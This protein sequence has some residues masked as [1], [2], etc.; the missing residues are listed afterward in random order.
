MCS[1]VAIDAL[2]AERSFCSVAPVVLWFQ[3]AAC[4]PWAFF[5]SVFPRC[6]L[7]NF[8]P[9][10]LPV[11]PVKSGP[12]QVAGFLFVLRE[13]GGGDLGVAVGF[14]EFPAFFS[15]SFFSVVLECG[16]GSLHIGL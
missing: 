9:R 12:S 10:W 13:S 16:L 1:C 2:V 7:G 6:F 15:S 5:G 14:L 8:L 4:L 3:I 11:L